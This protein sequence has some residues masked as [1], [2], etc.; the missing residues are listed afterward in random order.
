M[1]TIVEKENATTHQAQ[2]VEDIEKLL[3]AE[4]LTPKHV[5]VFAGEPLVLEQRLAIVEPLTPP[6]VVALSPEAPLTP[7]KGKRQKVTKSGK[8]DGRTL[9]WQKANNGARA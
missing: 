2:T 6:H 5:L 8:I 3:T 9:R 4:G 1:Y 7:V